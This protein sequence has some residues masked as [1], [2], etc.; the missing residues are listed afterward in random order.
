MN[1][2]FERNRPFLP[3]DA[4]FRPVF[5]RT[6]WRTP[7]SLAIWPKA[8]YSSLPCCS[9]CSALP[10]SLIAAAVNPVIM[11]LTSLGMPSVGAVANLTSL[12]AADFGLIVHG[13]VLIVENSLRRT[14]EP[15]MLPE[16]FSRGTRGSMWSSTRRGEMIRASCYDHGIVMLVYVPLLTFYIKA[17]YIFYPNDVLANPGYRRRFTCACH[18]FVLSGPD[19]QHRYRIGRAE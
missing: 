17:S 16:G 11:V 9:P 6:V 7:P 14:G 4:V 8:R 10:L 12:G 13:A 2:R 3:P 18:W 15:G 5:V 1:G 19:H